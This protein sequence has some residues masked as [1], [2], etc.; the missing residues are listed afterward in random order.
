MEVFVGDCCVSRWVLGNGRVD[1]CPDW[2]PLW[3][4]IELV[5]HVRHH[6]QRTLFLKYCMS[7]LMKSCQYIPQS[8]RQH[9]W[10]GTAEK[11]C[12]SRYGYSKHLLKMM[13]HRE[14]VG[15]THPFELLWL[16]DAIWAVTQNSS[17]RKSTEKWV[18]QIILP[19]LAIW[20][21]YSTLGMRAM[22][23]GIVA[24]S[25]RKGTL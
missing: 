20:I 17:D 21:L 25:E 22:F 3:G 14:A 8:T 2:K 15:W 5:C 19:C 7:D 10:L 13:S 24:N 4:A 6:V 18:S 12:S 23:W 16:E 11:W 1:R 9:Q